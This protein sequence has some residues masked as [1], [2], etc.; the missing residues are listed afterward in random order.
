MEGNYFVVR[1]D[2]AGV[3]CGNIKSR[4]DGSVVMTNVRK[5][6]YWTG[7]CAVEQ[8]AQKGVGAGS[9][10]TVTVPEMEIANPIQVIPCTNEAEMNLKNQ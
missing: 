9:K 3:F 5:I 10:L 1:A 2:R 8:I 4:T 6:Y 7:A